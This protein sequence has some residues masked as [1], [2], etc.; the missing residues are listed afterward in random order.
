MVATHRDAHLVKV[1]NVRRFLRIRHDS[2]CLDHAGMRV[3]INPR[4][5]LSWS[6]HRRTNH[7][8]RVDFLVYPS[9]FTVL[10]LIILPC[11]YT[12]DVHGIANP[13]TII[14]LRSVYTTTKSGCPFKFMASFSRRL[15]P[16]LWYVQQPAA[17]VGPCCW[18]FRLS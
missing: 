5:F 1:G 7:N 10:L 15:D 17:G 6:L 3:Y 2:A 18:M 9:T 4:V 8:M 16:S 11:L 12:R 14:N 13:P